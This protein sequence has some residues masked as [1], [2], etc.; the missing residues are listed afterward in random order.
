MRLII[1]AIAVLLCVQSGAA[2]ADQL[3][4]KGVKVMPKLTCV[5]R[6]GDETLE[7][8]KFILPWTV[9][10]VNGDWLWIG[11]ALKGWV[12]KS[13]VVR[14]NEAPAY[15]TGQI[16]SD[17]RNSWAFNMR[18]IAR[19][20]EGD[21][22]LAIADYSEAL[23]LE[24]SAVFY[25]N[26]GVAYRLKKDLDNAISDFDQAIRLNPTFSLAYTN[27]GD[28]WLA[29]KEYIKAISDYEQAIRCDPNDADAYFDR[30]LSWHKKKEYRKAIA[31]FDQ[32]IRL[33][34]NNTNAYNGS[35]WLLATYPN[36]HLPQWQASGRIGDEG[37]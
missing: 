4:W 3:S 35:A 5:V 34:P 18:A 37:L 23:R 7:R 6:V 19:K 14:M 32:A 27:R 1:I 21:L 15:Y 17:L 25:G 20:E 16:S 22:D 28:T 33:D 12:Q 36:P 10:D 9:Q 24:T 31:D 8:K 13:Q 26:R 30:G 2:G 11:H 29:K